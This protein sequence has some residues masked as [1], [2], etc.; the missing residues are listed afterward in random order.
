MFNEAIADNKVVLTILNE[1]AADSKEEIWFNFYRK[2][3]SQKGF[4]EK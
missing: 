2:T 1:I 3:T 4:A